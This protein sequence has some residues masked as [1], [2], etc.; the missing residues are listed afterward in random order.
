MFYRQSIALFGI[1]LPL[2][3]AA[4]VVGGT[5]SYSNDMAKDF[6]EKQKH[7]KTYETNRIG[8]L[9]IEAQMS[10]KRSSVD[11]WKT[12]LS[13][14]TKSAM[15]SHLGKIQ[16]MLPSKEFQR[17][18]F[19]PLNS[20][21]GFGGMSAQKSSQIHLGFRG[22]F[23]SVQRAFLELETRMPQLQLQE[24]KMDPAQGTNASLLNFDLTY[25]AWEN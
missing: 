12:Q 7:F 25:T 21:G 6:A 24:L 3:V 16:E 20:I 15:S 14:E 1:V 19:E 13:E 10:R 8:G 23:R 17:T 5:F 2:I 4:I 22:T 11:Q 18:A 9:G